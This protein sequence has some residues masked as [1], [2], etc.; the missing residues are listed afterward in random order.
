MSIRH[1]R[2]MN[3]IRY[4]RRTKHSKLKFQKVQLRN[5]ECY[6]GLHAIFAPSKKLYIKHSE[7]ASKP[8]NIS[9]EYP[10]WNAR[11]TISP[12]PASAPSP[13]PIPE[14]QSRS[15]SSDPSDESP[16]SH[17]LPQQ[18][19]RRTRLFMFTTTNFASWIEKKFKDKDIE[20]V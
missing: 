17:R 4:F 15:K 5:C 10:H 13:R 8:G 19:R 2:T 11:K 20:A 16:P 14:V 9:Q 7:A 1:V 12:S 3:N 6:P 18:Y